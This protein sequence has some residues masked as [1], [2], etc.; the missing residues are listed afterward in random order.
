M[1]RINIRYV[2]FYFL[3]YVIL[4]LPILYKYS[5]GANMIGFIYLGFLLFLPH[6]LQPVTKLLIGFFTGL[7]IDIFTNTPG[8]HAGISVFT[9]F[10]RDIYLQF[11]LG[12]LDGNPNLSIYSLKFKGLIG[13]LLPFV[14]IHLLILFIIDNGG[15]S[16]FFI[17]LWKAILSSIFTFLSIVI[18]NFAI[19]RKSARV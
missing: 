18:L 5:L 6:G 16:G 10:I 9:L 12:D 19:V 17:L 7:L 15:F 4:Q 14:F 2:I 13:Y 8:L 3:V 1:T 11:L